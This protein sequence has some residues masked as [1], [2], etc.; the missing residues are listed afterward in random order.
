M[1]V[2]EEEVVKKKWES[3][4]ANRKDLKLEE[5]AF[6]PNIIAQ[7]DFPK[8]LNIKNSSLSKQRR[9]VIRGRRLLL[10]EAIEGKGLNGQR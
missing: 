2:I 9:L 5:M 1:K 3:A 7:A 10:P 8:K 6:I 4:K